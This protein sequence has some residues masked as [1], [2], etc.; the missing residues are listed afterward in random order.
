MSPLVMFGYLARR[1]PR[2]RDE[3]FPNQLVIAGMGLH[4][5]LLENLDQATRSPCRITCLP[6]LLGPGIDHGPWRRG[7]STDPARLIGLART[8]SGLPT[9]DTRCAG[10]ILNHPRPRPD[11]LTRRRGFVSILLPTVEVVC[12]DA[13]PP[14]QRLGVR[15]APQLA[16]LLP[17]QR[18]SLDGQ[19]CVTPA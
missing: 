9:D 3:A 18:V 17:H 5:E 6:L 4:A 13:Q 15:T 10:R 2:L 7:I 16:P 8:C 14:G 11:P 19:R 12:A 1:V